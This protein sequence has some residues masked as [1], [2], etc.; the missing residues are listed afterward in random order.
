MTDMIEALRLKPQGRAATKLALSTFSGA[1]LLTAVFLTSKSVNFVVFGLLPQQ[2]Q[3]HFQW[4]GWLSA[5]AVS[6]IAIIAFYLLSATF[7][8]RH[9]EKPRLVREQVVAQIELLGPMTGRERAAIIGIAVFLLGGITISLHKIHAAWLGLTILYGL[10]I[11]GFL[12]KGE[13]RKEIDWPFLIYLGGMIGITNAF[14]HLGLDQWVA[15]RLGFIGEYMRTDFNLFLLILAGVI[16][17]IR[18]AVP[19]SATIVICATVF[20]PTASLHGINPWVMGFA[21]LMLGEMWFFPY[22]CSYYLQFRQFS[23][24]FDER[25]FLRSNSVM[26]LIK[27]AAL[28][29]SVPYWAKLGLI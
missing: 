25:M 4:L 3:F 20:M 10:L 29:A 18:L 24:A 14:N 2:D 7:L 21:I 6:G 1:T 19:F 22:Q 17:V 23:R 5:A 13:F 11:L 15:A 28:F 9:E 16:F 12:R 26:N 27:L 8:L